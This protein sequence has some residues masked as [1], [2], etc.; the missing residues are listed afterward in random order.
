[1]QKPDKKKFATLAHVYTS[2][3]TQGEL[4]NEYQHGQGL[5]VFLFF[6]NISVFVVWNKVASAMILNNSR[7]NN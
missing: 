1:M 6:L 2:E 5:D 7:N 4:S 3:S